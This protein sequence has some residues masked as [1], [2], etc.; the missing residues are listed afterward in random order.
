MSKKFVWIFR[1]HVHSSTWQIS[2]IT[3]MTEICLR[4][5]SYYL[6]GKWYGI[7]THDTNISN[8]LKPL[9]CFCKFSSQSYLDKYFEVDDMWFNIVVIIVYVYN[10]S[11]PAMLFKRLIKHLNRKWDY[12][13]GGVRQYHKVLNFL[14]L[15]HWIYTKCA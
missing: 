5:N 3:Y 12:T 7:P 10:I 9:T 1:Y 11:I 15:A 8:L 13:V 4:Y 6:Y 2:Y 14:G